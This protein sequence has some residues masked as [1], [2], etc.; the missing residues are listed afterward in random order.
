LHFGVEKL[1]FR[2]IF[3]KEIRTQ[4]QPMVELLYDIMITLELQSP[5]LNVNFHT[6]ST[7]NWHGGHMILVRPYSPRPIQ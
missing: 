5:V 7:K 3:Q 6:T 1:N 2:F 4:Y